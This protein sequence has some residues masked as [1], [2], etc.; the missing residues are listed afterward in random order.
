M[1][2]YSFLNVSLLV[3][4]V[5]ISG[6]AEGDDV[7]QVARREDSTQDVVGADGEMSLA[8]NANRSGTV[9]FRLQQTS[10]S[11]AYLSGLVNVGEV[12]GL[13]TT[14]TV[15][16]IDVESGD[17]AVG[18]KGYITKPADMARGSN[19]N[20]QEWVLVVENLYMLNGVG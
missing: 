12:G 14:V 10:N 5:E 11:N 9:T 6:Y 18:T 8:L 2:E 7:I 4:G 1:K 17:L 3:N 15:Q 13:G 16:M 20:A 19:S